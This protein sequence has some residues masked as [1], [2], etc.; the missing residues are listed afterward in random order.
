LKSATLRCR[1][2]GRHFKPKSH[3]LTLVHTYV[4][5]LSIFLSPL[6]SFTLP[7]HS[8]SF[9]IPLPPR[10]VAAPNPAKGFEGAPMSSPS[11]VW[12]KPTNKSCRL[13]KLMNNDSNFYDICNKPLPKIRANNTSKTTYKQSLNHTNYTYQDVTNV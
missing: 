11:V 4:Y 7:F 12:I 8:L 9:H 6:G 13:F 1:I 10:R 3:L 2:L 5:F